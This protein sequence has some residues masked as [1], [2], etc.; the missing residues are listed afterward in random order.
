MKI[1]GMTYT[2]DTS[3][4]NNNS[5]NN[6]KGAIHICESRPILPMNELLALRFHEKRIFQIMITIFEH[7]RN[8]VFTLF[9]L[10]NDMIATH[11]KNYKLAP[12]F[13]QWKKYSKIWCKCLLLLLLPC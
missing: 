13:Y 12:T 10:R 1:D 11:K 3:N 2:D 8:H 6:N 9:Y 5:N 4:S 7:W